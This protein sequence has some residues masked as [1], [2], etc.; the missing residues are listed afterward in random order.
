[1][2]TSPYIH[3]NNHDSFNITYKNP[4]INNRNL[5]YNNFGTLPIIHNN[6]VFHIDYF[7]KHVVACD[8]CFYAKHKHLPFP[9]NAAS[10]KF[11]WYHNTQGHLGDFFLLFPLCYNMYIS[12]LLLMNI[13]DSVGFTWQDSNRK[14]LAVLNSLFL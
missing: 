5:W 9:N 6:N 4:K 13:L 11:F 12:L 1:M 8:S 2:L 14:P 3:N 10:C 7:S